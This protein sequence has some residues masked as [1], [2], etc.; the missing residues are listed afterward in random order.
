MVRAAFQIRNSRGS[1]TGISG[2]V[3]GIEALGRF[4]HNPRRCG[5]RNKDAMS[6]AEEAVDVE[7]TRRI[8]RCTAYPFFFF[9]TTVRTRWLVFLFAVAIPSDVEAT[10]IYPPVEKSASVE[11]TQVVRVAIFRISTA[12]SQ[13]RT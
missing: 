13:W 9:I 3:T 11:S 10:Q 1:S 5:R 2:G 6:M 12:D 4:Y 7:A 8:R